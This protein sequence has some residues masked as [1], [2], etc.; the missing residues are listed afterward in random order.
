MIALM[1]NAALNAVKDK[2]P[3]SSTT[4]GTSVHISHDKATPLGREITA[5]AI[6]TKVD[7][8]KLTFEVF[9]YDAD[10]LI[11]KGTHTRYIVDRD[12]FLAKL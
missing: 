11:G 1:E 7:G 10:N 3:E 4:V 5:K 6:L 12:R 8:R 2:L 9:A